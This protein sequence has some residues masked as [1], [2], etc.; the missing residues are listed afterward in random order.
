MATRVFVRLELQWF[1]IAI[2]ACPSCGLCVFFTSFY[3]CRSVFQENSTSE[4]DL[5]LNKVIKCSHLEC[6]TC[7]LSGIGH[8]I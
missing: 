3:Y 4:F 2:L 1:R 7:Q 6:E 5:K 8:L